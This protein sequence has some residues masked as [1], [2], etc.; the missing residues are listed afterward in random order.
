MCNC[1]R[2]IAC[3]H[4]QQLRQPQAEWQI[5]TSTSNTSDP[6]GSHGCQSNTS[7]LWPALEARHPTQ[8]WAS[9]WELKPVVDW[10]ILLQTPTISSQTNTD[11][12]QLER[13][14]T[15]NTLNPCLGPMQPDFNLL[16]LWLLC[17]QF[18]FDCWSRCSIFPTMWWCTPIKTWLFRFDWLDFVCN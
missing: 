8:A 18:V 11:T 17:S 13:V 16:H 15:Q 2:V 10:L 1:V 6:G 5:T 12:F 14:Q 9:S 7:T 4:M 3:I